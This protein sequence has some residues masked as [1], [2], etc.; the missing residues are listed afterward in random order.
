VSGLSVSGSPTTP[1][2]LA[3]MLEARS[4]AVV[5]ASARAGSFGEQMMLQLLGGG[6]DGEVY[7]VNSRYD[8]ILGR[9]CY[10]SLAEIRAGVDLAILGVANARLE[11]QLTAA[12]EAGARSAVIFASCHE[13]PVPGQ[14]PLSRRL[15]EIARRAGMTICGGNGMGFVNV[16]RSLRACGFSEPGDLRPGPVTLITHSGS[17]F[18]AFLHNDRG[19]RFNLAVSSGLELTTTVADYLHYALGLESTAVVALFIET[20]RDPD[21]FRAA[22][23]AAERRD[24]PVVLLKVGRAAEARPLVQAHSGALAGEDAAYDAV[25]DAH[26]ALRVGSLD[27]MADTVE[28]LAAERRAAPGGLAAI[29]DSGGE[30]AHLIDAA[31]EIG[32]PFARISS[33]TRERLTGVL[34]EGLPAVN[35]L[36]AWG[37][38]RNHETIYRE[39]IRALLDD[40]DTGALAFVVDLTTQEAKEEGYLQVARDAFPAT[41]KP[42]AMLSNLRSAVDRRDAASLRALGI[43]VLEGTPSGLA[44]FAHLFAYRDHRSRPAPRIGPGPDPDV[45]ERWRARISEGRP[46]AEAEGLALLADYGVPVVTAETC[47]SLEGA[48]AAARRLGWPVAVKTAASSVAHKSDVDGVRLGLRDEAGVREAYRDLS[49]RLGPQVTVS[50]MATSGVELALGVVRDD[51]FGPMVMVAAGGLLVEV[52]RDRRFALP[53][54]DQARALRLI[55]GLAVRRLLDGTRGTPPADVEAVARAVAR[56]SVLAQGLG[57]CLQA[58]DVNPLIAGPTGCVA[59]DALVVPREGDSAA[60]AEGIQDRVGVSWTSR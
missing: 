46:F 49:E 58:L 12:A 15:T 21:S 32:V 14:A 6:F 16:E 44:A 34:E 59:V 35:P 8:H 28:L 50:E 57:D 31:A 11:E 52:L 27:E 48:L 36:D 26:G 4:V 56:L 29:H 9:P 42:F 43:P 23:S 37:T 45:A 25:F 33:T 22:L 10:P 41:G 39:C 51:Q 53:P 54:V 60:P 18:S 55:E 17:V 5:G 47:S 24:V 3:S 30:R 19:I 2:T 13:P 20:V 40:P 1:S 38:G 7:P